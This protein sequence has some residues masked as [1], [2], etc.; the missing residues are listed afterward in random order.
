MIPIAIGVPMA[1]GV[2]PWQKGVMARWYSTLAK[3]FFGQIG[4]RFNGLVTNKNDDG[5]Q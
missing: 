5:T 3:S 4:E 2:V 1:N